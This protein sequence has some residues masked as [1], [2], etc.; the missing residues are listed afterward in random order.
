MSSFFTA[1]RA[2]RTTWRSRFESLLA[3]VDER[4]CVTALLETVRSGRWQVVSLP[5]RR[6]RITGVT[7]AIMT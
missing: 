1:E 6:A 5:L 2:G 4:V 7:E 3:A